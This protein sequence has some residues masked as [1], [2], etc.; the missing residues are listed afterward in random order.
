MNA[1]RAM[2]PAAGAGLTSVTS[3][4]TTV[5]SGSVA[6]TTRLAAVPATVDSGPP[7]VTV[8]G[9]LPV[10][11]SKVWAPKPSNVSIGEAVPLGGGIEGVGRRWCRRR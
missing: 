11:G 2:V 8:I 9:W 3:T 4:S 1:V 10:P 6:V 7:Q 5:P